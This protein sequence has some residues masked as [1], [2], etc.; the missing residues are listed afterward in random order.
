MPNH[1]ESPI[2]VPGYNR[3]FVIVEQADQDIWSLGLSSA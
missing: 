3:A 2:P 1:M